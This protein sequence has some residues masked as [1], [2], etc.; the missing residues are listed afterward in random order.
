MSALTE[1]PRPVPDT[2]VGV[3]L[4]MYF[5]HEQTLAWCRSVADAVAGHPALARGGTELTVLPSYPSLAA[6]VDIFRDTPVTVGAQ[7]VSWADHGPY[8]GEVNAAS[9]RQVGCSYAEIGHAERKRYF[10]EEGGRISAKV[11]AALRGGLTPVVCVGESQ[12]ADAASAAADCLRGLDALPSDGRPA[13]VAYEPEWAI[14]A[15]AAASVEHVRDVVGRIKAGLAAGQGAPN[16][17]VIYG[18]SAGPGLLTALGGAVDGLFLGRF[19]HDPA[20]VM[21][22]L[23]EA[24]TRRSSRDS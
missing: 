24:A 11:R 1:R 22:I 3:S 9:L 5:D 2:F 17:R 20:A 14:G 15:E 7:D 6:A 21:Q 8:T 18:G 12:Q 10:A 13:V 23:D 19:A 4:K 16:V